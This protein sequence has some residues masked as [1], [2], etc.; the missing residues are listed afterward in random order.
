MST[1]LPKGRPSPSTTPEA[2]E[3]KRR[4][5]LEAAAAE[6]AQ[7]GFDSASIESIAVR[8]GIGK[9]TIYGYTHSKDQLYS[10]CLQLI[11]DEM[12]QF[13]EETVSSIVEEAMRAS[14]EP[15]S[16][17]RFAPISE[18]LAHLAHRRQDFLAMYFDSIFGVNP[19]GRDLVVP[20]A[21]EFIAGLEQ[22]FMAAQSHG[23]V[24]TDAPAGMI[25]SLV[26]MNRLA[27]PRMVDGLGLGTYSPTERTEFL[28]EMHWHGIAKPA[29]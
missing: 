21:R 11:A 16:F 22:L 29:P 10:A 23:F 14:D 1:K 6:F 18:Q 4:R 26:F 17:H 12:H 9:G 20:S 13:L 8:A 28:F 24:R 15:T 5:I 3:A 2:R 25:A 19:R 7:F 27:F